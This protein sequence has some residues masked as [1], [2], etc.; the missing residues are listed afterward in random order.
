[1]MDENVPFVH[2]LQGWR[3]Y[4][5]TRPYTPEI[6]RAVDYNKLSRSDQDRYD[7]D[8]LVYHSRTITI[9]TP[10]IDQLAKEARVL[11][12]ANRHQIG[13][14]HG[15]IVSGPPTTGKTTAL[16]PLGAM[17][18]Q[19]GRKKHPEHD[20]A[21]VAFLSLPPQATPKSISRSI[22][23]FFGID[24]PSRT[25]FQELSY[26]ALGLLS[27]L[28]TDLLI[29]DEIHNLTLRRQAGAE[30]SDFLKYLAERI[31]ATMVY[32]GVEVEHAGLFDG[33][34]GRQLAGRFTLVP[35]KPFS[36]ATDTDRQIW[37]AL[38]SNFETNLRLLHHRAGTLVRLGSYLYTRTGGHIGSLANLVRKAAITAI[39]HNSECIKRDLLETIAID[40]AAQN[41][42]PERVRAF[43]KLR[44]A[45]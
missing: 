35:A 25:T 32:A 36:Y 3:R 21:P 8:R 1:M 5:S 29:I 23:S 7:D 39:T 11:L 9:H 19:R 17:A 45:G 16:L 4:V 42:E 38:V 34:R 22:I 24:P 30:A 31:G 20:N 43:N 10:L 13:A 41:S 44:R 12:I 6:L 37:A 18:E 33:V 26:A 14:R 40:I 27:D 28:K 15:I 2:T